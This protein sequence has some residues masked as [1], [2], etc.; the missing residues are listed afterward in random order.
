MA[1]QS[2]VQPGKERRR[3]PHVRRTFLAVTASLSLLVTLVSGAAMG[4]YIW[5]QH[6]IQ[7]IGSLE[8]APTPAGSGG[9]TAPATPDFTGKCAK[10]SCNYLL[11]GSDSRAGLTP[12]QQVQ[13]GTNQD[14]GG[15]NRSDTIIVVHTQPDQQKATFLSFPRDLWVDIPGVGYGRINSAFS[16]GINH[17]GAQMVARTI[18]ALTGIQIDHILYVDLAGFEGLVNALGGVQM[19][20][21]YPM[22]DPLT[23]LDIPAGC[24]HFDGKTALAYVRTRHQICDRIPDFARIARQ[25]QFLRAIIAKLLS[26]RELLHLP[27]LVPALLD[28]LRVDEGLKNPAEL[29]YLAGQLNGV[30]TG[31]A[32]FRVVP[33]VPGGTYVNGTYLSIVNLVQPQAD[34]LFQRIRE[35]EPLG[36]LGLTQEL[37][38]PSPAVIKTVVYARGG[39]A[40]PSPVGLPTPSGSASPSMPTAPTS[41]P[42]PTSST[43]P[44]PLPSATPASSA[45]SVFDTLTMAGFDTSTPLQP[46]SA[47]GELPKGI[48]GSVILYDPKVPDGQAMADVVASY[49]RNMKEMPA[50]KGL[51]PAGVDVAVIVAPGYELPPPPTS[52]PTST[53]ECP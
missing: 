43:T 1:D 9:P 50:P 35:N 41:P 19:C 36:D 17:G 27:S 8:V 25:Q 32:D 4:A 12:E 47:L 22:Q 39:S 6:Q 40:S 42:T 48:R 34:E 11:L 28:N 38:P 20:V 45:A 26:P 31:N 15:S 33:T 3:H 10:T 23:A 13:F 37:T 46:L 7:T 24:Q 49:L 52:G 16:L 30:N 5:T 51:L 29:A 44:M 53:S 14:I 18:R 2:S 21:P